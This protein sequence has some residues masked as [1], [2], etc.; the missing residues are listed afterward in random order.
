M[1]QVKPDGSSR[2]IIASGLRNTIGFA[3]QPST[4]E[5]YGWDHGID[6]LGDNAQPEELNLIEEGHKYGWPYIYGMGEKNIQH[7]PPGSI[8]HD[9]WAKASD[10][11]VLTHTAHAAPMQFAFYTGDQFPGAYRGDAFIA[12][13]GSW[14]RNPPSGYEVLRVH[15]E[16]GRPKSLEPFVTGFLTKSSEGK[17]GYIG[18]PFGIAVAPDGALYIGD[19]ANGAIYRVT[20][21]S[22]QRAQAT[23]G[24]TGPEKPATNAA[25]PEQDT[26]K[27]LARAI[28]GAKDS[29]INLT[30]PAF[31]DGAKMNLRY[32]AYGENISPELNWSAG[33]RGTQSYALLIEDP[34]AQ[35]PKP[36]VHWILY[37]VPPDVTHLREGLPGAPAL[38]DPKDARQ[39]RN[40][41]GT[42]SYTGPRPPDPDPHH[43]H[44]QLFALDTKFDLKPG[45]GRKEV[46][47][48]MQ[49]HI[50]ASGELVGVFQKPARPPAE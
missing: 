9:D 8:T 20:Y 32:S 44:F 2:K 40:T 18:R 17:Y 45:A 12:F 15:F 36:V 21:E 25:L 47:A 5:M 30:S 39:G 26:P 11:P 31:A 24:N 1:L 37:N 23:A 3:F 42:N 14:N 38:A 29:D 28:L 33:P 10:N 4:G 13:H 43:Y 48:A 19:D 49:G 41:R 50:L 22:A 46:L 34:D 35:K 16:D 6:W 27:E 7:D